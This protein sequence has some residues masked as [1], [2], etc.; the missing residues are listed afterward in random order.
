MKCGHHLG[1]GKWRRNVKHHLISLVKQI[2]IDYLDLLPTYRGHSMI[3]VYM[4][5]IQEFV[6][7]CRFWP[8]LSLDF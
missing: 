8:G 1:Y 7:N 4:S 5:L 2:G 6:V 3:A